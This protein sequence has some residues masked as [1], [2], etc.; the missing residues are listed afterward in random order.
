MARNIRAGVW[1]YDSRRAAL[2]HRRRHGGWVVT[3]GPGTGYYAVDSGFD[4]EA[5][6]LVLQLVDDSRQAA[7]AIV[8]QPRLRADRAPLVTPVLARRLGGLSL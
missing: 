1:H 7:C 5:E 3:H 8:H 6:D 4:K 2:A